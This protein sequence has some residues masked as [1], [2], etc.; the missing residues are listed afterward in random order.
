MLRRTAS[1]FST[2]SFPAIVAVPLLGHEPSVSVVTEVV[3]VAAP[4]EPT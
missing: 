1:G 4:I 2:K 3:D